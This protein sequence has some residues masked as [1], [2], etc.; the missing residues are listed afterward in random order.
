[1]W[2]KAKE[3]KIDEDIGVRSLESTSQKAP[4]LQNYI[5]GPSLPKQ[6]WRNELFVW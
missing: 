6:N 4:L 5:E 3:E 2:G 1:M